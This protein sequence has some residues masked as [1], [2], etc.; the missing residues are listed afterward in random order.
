[1]K[2][3]LILMLLLL[4]QIAAIN[5]QAQELTQSRLE[6]IVRSDYLWVS[7]RNAAGLVTF[8]RDTIL[9]KEISDARIGY[10]FTSG[11]FH[12]VNDAKNSNKFYAEASSCYRFNPRVILS[13][14][15]GYSHMAGNEMGG[16][17]WLN[18]NDT[19]FNITETADSTRGDKSRNLY[20]LFG[21]IGLDIS[22]NWSMGANID[23]T[24]A[25]N[26]KQKDPRQKSTYLNFIA[27]PGVRYEHGMLSVGANY[28]Y[29]RQIENITFGTYGRQDILYHYLI[30][31]GGYF[32][33]DETTDGSGYTDDSNTKP[34]VDERQGA[35][36]QIG[37]R[38]TDRF[39]W[40]NE[41]TY[42]HRYGYYG[43]E[44]PSLISFSKHRANRWN[45]DGSL[46]WFKGV[47]KHRWGLHSY[48]EK[49]INDE[50]VY[51]SETSSGGI[52][53][54]RYYGE[55]EA[56]HRKSGHLTLDYQ[57]LFRRSGDDNLA[58]WDVFGCIDYS[59]LQQTASF[60]PFYRRQ[61]INAVS[62]RGGI[63][64]YLY[65]GLNHFAIGLAPSFHTGNGDCRKDGTYAQPSDQQLQPTT[66]NLY[67]DRSFEYQT[68]TQVAIQ[69]HFGY[70]RRIMGPT[71]FY[72][73]I[74]GQWRKAFSIDYLEGS[75]RFNTGIYIG[76][77]F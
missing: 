16:S 17:V 37:L 51:R 49:L 22:K 31:Q 21:A 67:A 13:G 39:E 68:S 71:C 35:S 23:Y 48:Y 9:Y 33:S 8:A 50:R 6:R 73:G 15:I 36:L 43:V 74:T 76:F 14:G 42:Q 62:L 61:E 28:S 7:S 11:D 4:C 54:I 27:S 40:F 53:D 66:S 65:N 20:H 45:Y 10:D 24:T 32:G 41:F 69:L 57:G 25:S 52:S 12:S 18:P 63:Q 47:S 44:S 55:R 26:A 19:P 5:I 59:Y 60:Y 1:M 72:A 29:H 56:N 2:K 70:T 58:S 34:L 77:S 46:R 3:Q 64:R 38:F 75:N 30:D